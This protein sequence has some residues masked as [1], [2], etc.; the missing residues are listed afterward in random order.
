MKHS[1][2]PRWVRWLDD[3]RWFGNTGPRKRDILGVEVFLVVCAVA[4]LAAS[5]AASNER[6]VRVLR[7]GALFQFVVA[8]LV[9]VWWRLC[10]HYQL[11]HE[12]PPAPRTRGQRVAEYM[13][14]FGVGL[15]AIA[16]I[17]WLI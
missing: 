14:A 9:T 2:R 13:Y 4:L 16:T 6:V 12:G 8:Y 10:D 5:F 3:T 15:T 7:A 17:V 11:W 1:N